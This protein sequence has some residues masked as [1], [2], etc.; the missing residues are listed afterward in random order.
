MAKHHPGSVPE[1]SDARARVD[2][3]EAHR[4]AQEKQNRRDIAR[5]SASVAGRPDAP[6]PTLEDALGP[7]AERLRREISEGRGESGG[8]QES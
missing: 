1:G 7:D 8:E 6:P 3:D 5:T 2:I 4:R